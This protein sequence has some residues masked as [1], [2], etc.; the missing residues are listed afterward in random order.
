MTTLTKSQE[1]SS[2]KKATNKLNDLIGTMIS[3]WNNPNADQNVASVALEEVANLMERID[4]DLRDDNIKLTEWETRLF[5]II[6]AKFFDAGSMPIAL[7]GIVNA[8]DEEHSM[9]F[10]GVN[11]CMNLLDARGLTKNLT[12]EGLNRLVAS[13]HPAREPPGYIGKPEDKTGFIVLTEKGK[14]YYSKNCI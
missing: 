8:A 6:G 9:G 13:I 11:I 14:L 5:K 1:L 3:T 10:S 2:D 7:G 12:N 4:P